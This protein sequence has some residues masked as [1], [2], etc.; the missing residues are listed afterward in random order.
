MNNAGDVLAV[1]DT[2]AQL[3]FCTIFEYKSIISHI[4]LSRTTFA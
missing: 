3:R 4:G 2:A 1:C